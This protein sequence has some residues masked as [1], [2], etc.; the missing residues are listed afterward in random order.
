MKRSVQI[1]WFKRDLRTSDHAPLLEAARMDKPILPLYIVEPGYWLQS[2]ASRRHWSFIH[3]C[4]IDLNDDLTSL[5]QSLVIRI[6]DSV[7]VFKSL[8]MDYSIEEIHTFEET[9]RPLDI[10]YGT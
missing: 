2:T 3:D 5:G 9:G 6:G 7:S 4:L 10:R 8:H 1:V